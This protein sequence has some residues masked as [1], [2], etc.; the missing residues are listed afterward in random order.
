MDKISH[1]QINDKHHNEKQKNNNNKQIGSSIK[2]I[3][4]LFSFV[5][6]NFYFLQ[7]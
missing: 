2:L 1:F 6:A 5:F 7:I 4:Y 3:N